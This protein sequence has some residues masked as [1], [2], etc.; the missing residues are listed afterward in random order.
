VE[1]PFR[2]RA[3]PAVLGGGVEENEEPPPLETLDRTERNGDLT[4][5]RAALAHVRAA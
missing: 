4:G 2:S 5:E 1:E 3:V